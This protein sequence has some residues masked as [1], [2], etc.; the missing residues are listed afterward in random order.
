MSQYELCL[1]SANFI[2]SIVDTTDAVGLVL[3]SGLGNLAEEIENPV[4]I[5]Y[6]DIPNFPVTTVPGHAGELVCG[7]INNVKILCMKGRFHFYEGHSMQTVAMP[8]RVMKLLGCKCVILTNAAGGCNPSFRP[9]T[10][11]VIDDFI[12]FMGDNPLYGEN[13]DRFGP[14]FPDM[15]KAMDQKLRDLTLRSA[16]ELNIDVQS[17]V[18]MSFRGP[19]FETPAEIRFAQRIGADAVGMSTVPEILV[20]RHCGLPVL[21]I[22]C[23]TNMAAGI[24]GEELTHEEVQETADRVNKDFRNLLKTVITNME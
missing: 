1:E 16:K 2:R 19:N 20:A 23:I 6:K 13:E 9:G 3:G 11:M 24:T 15:T 12:N 8:V 14:R 5:R 4:V 22:S 10:L 21:G 18:Y 7:Y 17:G